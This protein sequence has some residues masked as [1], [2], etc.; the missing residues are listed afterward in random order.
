VALPPTNDTI[1]AI[2]T[3]PGTGAVGVVRVSGPEAYAVA[4]AVFVPARGGRPSA[5]PAGRV[6]FGRVAAGDEVVDEALLLT[7]RAPASYTG[8]DVVELQT[9]GGPAVLRRVLDLCLAAGARSAG[10][11]EFTLRAYLNGKLDLAQAE[12]AKL[13]YPRYVAD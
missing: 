13:T 4:D 6:L 10:P 2:A 9:H 5:A 1:A 11:G 3:A 8:Q 12:S 7:F